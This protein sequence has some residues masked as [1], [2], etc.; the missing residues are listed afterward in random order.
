VGAAAK[1]F[2]ANGEQVGPAGAGEPPNQ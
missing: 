1:I 2:L